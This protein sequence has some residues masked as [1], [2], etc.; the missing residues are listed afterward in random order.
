[1]PTM[2]GLGETARAIIAN[3]MGILAADETVSTITKR[4]SAR[5]IESTADSRR[6]YR[7]LLFSTPGI[8]EY[9]GGVI[10]QDETI[11]QDS[12]AGIPLADL[13]VGRGIIPGIKVDA[14]VHPL[15]GA[16]GEFVTEGLD[17]LRERLKE[18]REL[19]ARFAKWRAVF[20]LRDGRPSATCIHAN[21]HALARYAALCQEQGLVPIVEPEVLMEGAHALARCEHVTGRVLQAVFTELFAARV[22]LEGMLLKP[23][24]VT[25]GHDS[26]RQASVAEVAEAT[27]R[28]L[29]R[30]VPPAVPG[31]V[32]L[33]GG[34]DA[35]LATEHLNAINALAGPKPWTLSFSF[36]R[37]LQDEALDA[38]RGQRAQVPA[39][40][41]AFHHR[42]WCDSAA[43]LGRYS[44][45]MEGEAGF[46]PAD[47]TLHTHH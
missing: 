36:G 2:P 40:Q 16:P 23:N 12:A 44:A 8:S 24:M 28:V 42:A 18:Y 38:W 14:G 26:A 17:G 25:E 47:S 41:R 19:G 20:T 6:A 35:V 3:G 29:T 45:A 27:L 31:I 11:H 39:A 34:Q 15:A 33:S 7:E 10:L 46:A 9:I 1:M 4:L 22:T 21:A 30:H 5:E 32:F 13:L 37:A 43:A